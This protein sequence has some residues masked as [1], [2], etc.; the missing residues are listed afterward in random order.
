MTP[1]V[2]TLER[3]MARKD[4]QEIPLQKPQGRGVLDGAW[5]RR[6]EVLD[7]EPPSSLGARPL[8]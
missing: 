2:C 1:L 3:K 8:V 4:P 7:S 5:L 6:P